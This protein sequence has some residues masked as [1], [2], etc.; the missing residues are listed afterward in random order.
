MATATE[1]RASRRRRRDEARGAVLRAALELAEGTP[2]KDLT[3]D[4]IARAA[5]VSRTA[6]YIHFRDKGELLLAAVD[7]VAAEL[8]EQA[9]RWWSGE[10]EPTELVR[11]ALAGVV[12]VY[13]E[14][15]RLLRLATEVS[16]Y[17]EE[18]RAF[19]LELMGRFITT[20]TAQIRSE[21]EAGRIDL[22]LDPEATAEAMVWMTER[23]CY[24]YLTR[25][26]RTPETV[27]ASL[28]AVWTAALYGAPS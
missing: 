16:T 10:G 3:V 19:W 13:A 20:A 4:E 9:D 23:Y 27:T 6:F 26:P 14:H 12:G 25:E 7:E 5:G 2:F 21:Q 24:I 22:S 1:Q 17:D 15:A 8:H 18:V 11:E 28:G